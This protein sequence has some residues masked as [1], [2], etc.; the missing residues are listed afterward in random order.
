[1]TL[2]CTRGLA[3]FFFF[4]SFLFFFLGF[5]FSLPFPGG[6]WLAIANLRTVSVTRKF[7]TD[8]VFLGTFNGVRA[9]LLLRFKINL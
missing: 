8:S 9:H 1:V 3:F 6:T 2:D 5:L 4:F 7:L